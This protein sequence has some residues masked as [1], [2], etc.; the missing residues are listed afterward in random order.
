MFQ[1]LY[2]NF[3]YS[4]FYAHKNDSSLS[5]NHLHLIY[6]PSPISPFSSHLPHLHSNM[7]PPHPYWAD[8][9][10]SDEHL[11]RIFVYNSHTTGPPHP[12]WTD[13]NHSDEHLNR[14][15]TYRLEVTEPPHRYWEDHEHDHSSSSEHLTS[16]YPTVRQQ[17]LPSPPPSVSP[18]SGYF[19][20]SESRFRARG[21]LRVVNTTPTLPETPPLFCEEDNRNSAPCRAEDWAL[22]SGWSADSERSDSSVVSLVAT[23]KKKNFGVLSGKKNDFF[24]RGLRRVSKCVGAAVRVA[25]KKVSP[26]GSGA[27]RVGSL[28]GAA[29]EAKVMDGSAGLHEE[30]TRVRVFQKI[31]RTLLCKKGPVHLTP[32]KV[33]FPL[34]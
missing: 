16:M 1:F 32:A 5:P 12:Y 28:D 20:P 7:E 18:D 29:E 13:H 2:S 15:V 14:L 19:S 30:R 27:E 11:N 9:D 22:S 26:A 3:L 23:K 6:L 25:G 34:D 10:H 21:K 24:S 8:H 33:R 17:R 31:K 4:N